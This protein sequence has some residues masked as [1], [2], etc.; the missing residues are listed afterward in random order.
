MR[1]I[2]VTAAAIA[3]LCASSSIAQDAAKGEKVFRKCRACHQVGPEAKS[4]VGPVLN[5]IVGRPFGSIEGFKYSKA[6]GAKAEE[7]AV[8]THE[9]LDQFLTKPRKHLKGTSMG[10]AGLKKES[11]RQDVIAYLATFDVDG[12]PATAEQPATTE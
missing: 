5:G 10:F 4:R 1:R 2:I 9:E 12:Q 11:D 7:G 6:I 8:W 3:T